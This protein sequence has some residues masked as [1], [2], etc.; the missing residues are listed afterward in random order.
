MSNQSVSTELDGLW[1]IN[2][3]GETVF[4]NDDMAQI[5]GTT[6]TDLMGKDS[7]HFVFPED[8]EAARRLFAEK[9]AGSLA[10]FHFRLRRADGSSVWADVQ[11]TPMR[12]AAGKFLG[13]VGSFTVSKTQGKKT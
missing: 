10:P 11:G 12:N 3:K 2:D 13:I 9:I 5:L 4:V 8:E 7:F 6:S 1:I